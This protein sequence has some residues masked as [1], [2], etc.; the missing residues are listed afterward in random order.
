MER[1]LVVTDFDERAPRIQVVLGA[2]GWAEKVKD[3]HPA[4]AELV[5]EFYTNIH[6][7]VGDSFPTWIRGTEI[8]VTYDLISAITGAPRVHNPE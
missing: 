7:R 3:H 8:N 2:Q 6:Q 5:R 4:I 1:G